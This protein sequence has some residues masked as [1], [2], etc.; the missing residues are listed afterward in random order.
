M[1]ECLEGQESDISRRVV[2]VDVRPRLVLFCGIPGSGKTTV[3]SV[4]AARLPRSVLIQTDKIRTMVATPKYTGA[5]SKF[6]YSSL[7]S[8]GSE[9]LRAGYDTLLEGTFPR[10][11]FRRD[12]LVALSPLAEKT[13][14][15]YLQCEPELAFGRNSGRQEVVPWE[16]FFR[17]FTQFEEPA[18]ALKIDTTSVSPQESVERILEALAG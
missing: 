18:S 2:T 1:E 17:I 11:E 9:A 16:R 5:E 13:L 6:V 14:T 12:A 8:V 4:L 3:A 10:E 7:I 15:V